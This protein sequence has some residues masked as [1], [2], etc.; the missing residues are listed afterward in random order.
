MFSLIIM[1]QGSLREAVP[2]PCTYEVLGPPLECGSVEETAEC[3]KSPQCRV[4]I[5]L[6]ELPLCQPI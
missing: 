4:D 1:G 3:A 2:R 6:L 5:A